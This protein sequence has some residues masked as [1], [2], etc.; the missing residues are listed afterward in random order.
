[1][2]DSRD[3]SPEGLVSTSGGSKYPNF[4]VD[5]VINYHLPPPTTPSPS[6]PLAE[7]EASFTQLITLLSKTGFALE[8]RPGRAPLTPTS[9]SSLLIFLRIASPS[10][11]EKQIYRY[12]VQDWLYGVRTAAPGP[13]NSLSAPQE[14]ITDAER[15]RLA[16]LLITKP[17]NEGGAGIT[18]GIGQWR[19][20]KAVF[21]LHDRKF[22]KEWITSWSTKYILDDSDLLKIRNQFGEK[23][24]FYF[25]FLQSYFQ[26]LL[27][28]ALFG[29]AAWL[30]LGGFSWVYAVVNCL[31]GVVFFEH[32]KMKEVDLAVQWGV[33]GVGKI[34]LPRPQFK[35]EREGVDEVTGEIVKVYSPY[36][37]L[38]RQLLQVPFAGACVCVLGGL[39]LGCFSIE[40]FITEVYMGPFKQYLT[41]LPTVLLTIFMPTF[42]TLLTKLA[43]RLTELENY[44]TVD[45]HQASF[46]QKI[47]VL[48]FITSY[49]GI[50]LTAFVYVP[51]GK[52]LVPYLDV[53]QLTAQ[54]FTAE[55]KPLPTKEWVINPD[56]LRKQVIYFTV[57]AQIV[58]FATEVVVPYA[59]RRIFRTVEKVQTEIKKGDQARVE[60]PKDAEEEERF[61]KRVREEAELGEYDVT[62]D[63]REMVI[64][65]GY[66]SLFSVV[67]PLTGC[68]FL[69]NN[70]VEARSDAVKIAA[71]SQRP[72]PWR[73]DSIGPWLDALGFLS[74]LGSVVSAALV[75]LFNKSGG[76][77]LG[78]GSVWDIPGW[79]L[80]LAVMGSEHVYLVVQMVVRGV[81]RRLDSPGLRKE[82]AE[83]FAMR[84]ELLE[85]MVEEEVVSEEAGEK[86]GW[87]GQREGISREVL[88][89]EARGLSGLGPEKRFW[90]RQRGA[91]ESVEVGRGLI[92]LVSLAGG[93]NSTV[94]R[95]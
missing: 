80:L 39:I 2:A 56:R 42:T 9:P 27:F 86:V 76:G 68:S 55:G 72:I 29:S 13:P 21:P 59:K 58:N 17:V 70:W 66:L 43:E 30:I 20:V 91:G 71:N 64:Q 62:I 84:R 36:K 88:E 38:A 12:R 63:Y 65:F 90:L 94:K 16:Y 37:R 51:F 6:G 78:V 60:W 14:P 53:F 3:S 77:Q 89:E 87:E 52:I 95:Q 25:A 4:E 73:A 44:E 11:L 41:F 19:F 93:N 54:K 34:Q 47:F 69:V 74:W 18:P 10:L 33:R 24:A 15:L 5:Y 1:M 35:F 46:V 45:A 7:A 85:R 40:I 83:R 81:I 8:V 82:R 31:W 92:Q 79:A 75:Y 22:N 50:F 49:L 48:N 26:F 23:V 61:L 57:T 28:P 67:W 32:W